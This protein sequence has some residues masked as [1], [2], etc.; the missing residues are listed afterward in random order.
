MHAISPL[1]SKP[2]RLFYPPFRRS[3]AGRLP[4]LKLSTPW[5]GA[6]SIKSVCRVRALIVGLK[7]R[8]ARERARN[9]EDRRLARAM[10]HRVRSLALEN[11]GAHVALRSR[12]SRQHR[13]ETGARALHRCALAQPIT[14]L[15]PGLAPF[16]S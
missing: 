2:A 8:R 6:F 4:L 16:L 15:S 12:R 9:L 13:W 10:A 5:S 14:D 1:C 11:A 7:K 3:T